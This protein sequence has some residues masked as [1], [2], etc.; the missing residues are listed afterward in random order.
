MIS[1]AQ[2]NLRFSRRHFVASMA[3]IGISSFIDFPVTAQAGMINEKKLTVKQIMDLI[4]KTIPGAP[5][6]ETVDTLKTGIEGQEV[7]GIV[8][9]MFPTI[10]IIRKAIELNANFII[11]HEPTF[12]N[13][14]DDTK[15]LEENKVYTFKRDLLDK[16]KIAVWRFHDYWHSHVPDGILNGFLIQLGWQKYYNPDAP[17]IIK[18]PRAQL[19]EII[20]HVKARLGIEQVRV[21]GDL[22]QSCERIALLPGAYGGRHQIG[23]LQNEEPDVILCGEVSE[24]ET[25]EYVRD[26]RA[27]GLATSLV[28]LGHAV[29]E[30]PGMLWLA[31]WLQ[32]KVPG[33]TVTHIASKDPFIRV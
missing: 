14:L 11:V 2:D 31:Q 28:V 33:I 30:E 26:L 13:H 12:Y 20:K 19:G 22:A 16:N 7:S 10:D 32:P 4:L 25:A 15:W 5:F 18:H 8:T 23:L 9:T 3:T 24:W 29:S 6:S 27:M 17:L 1:A 21:V